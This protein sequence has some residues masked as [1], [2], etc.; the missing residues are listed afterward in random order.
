MSWEWLLP[1]EDEFNFQLDNEDY[2]AKL[3]ID[4][5]SGKITTEDY[6]HRY[7]KRFKKYLKQNKK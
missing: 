5:M 4:Y 3:S 2:L 1:D 6:Y 7:N